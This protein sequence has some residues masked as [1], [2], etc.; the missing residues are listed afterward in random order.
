MAKISRCVLGVSGYTFSKSNGPLKNGSRECCLAAIPPQSA[1]QAKPQLAHR[2]PNWCSDAF[3]IR[4][5]NCQML[6]CLLTLAR[7]SLT[8]SSS[9]W[10]SFMALVI[11]LVSFKIWILRVYG[12]YFTPNGRLIVLVNSLYE[13]TNKRQSVSRGKM[14]KMEYCPLV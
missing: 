7:A 13:K 5:G 6:S 3:G 12:L 10:S 11:L 1:L 4:T 9:C 8:T 2:P 14:M